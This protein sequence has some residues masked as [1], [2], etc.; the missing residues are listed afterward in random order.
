MKSREMTR[1]QKLMKRVDF[2][3]QR[4]LFERDS[5]IFEKP[6][7]RIIEVHLRWRMRVTGPKIENNDGCALGTAQLSEKEVRQINRVGTLLRVSATLILKVSTYFVRHDLPREEDVGTSSRDK[8]IVNSTDLAAI[9]HFYLTCDEE[10]IFHERLRIQ[11]IFAIQVMAYTAARPGSI[12]EPY[13][14]CGTNDGLLY[15]D[16]E[17]MLVRV[18][19]S[20]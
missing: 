12:M 18:D 17:V 3:F 10:P 5:G 20:L 15:K 2:T 7:L 9:I 19:G 4:E 11:T 6:D 14:H 16:V 8:P 1:A 13:Y